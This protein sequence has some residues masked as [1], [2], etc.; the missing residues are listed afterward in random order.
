MKKLLTRLYID[1]FKSL[2]NFSLPATNEDALNQFVCLVGL[3]GSGK[4]SV[5][6]ALDFLSSL[7][8][9]SPF[10]W[11]QSRKWEPSSLMSRSSRKRTINFRLGFEVPG[12][13]TLAWQAS[14]NTIEARCITEELTLTLSSDRTIL[15]SESVSVKFER[16]LVRTSEGSPISLTSD[17]RGSV[18]STLKSSTLPNRARIAVMLLKHFLQGIKSLELL[19]PHLMRST[20]R[21]AVDVGVGGERLAAFINGLS[22]SEKKELS[23]TLSKFYPRLRAIGTRSAQYGWRRVFVREAYGD[24]IESDARHMND[25]MLRIAAIVAQT[26]AKSGFRKSIQSRESNSAT[27]DQDLG[28]LS[29]KEYALIL[30]DEI[31]NGVNPELVQLLIEYLTGVRQQVIVTTHSAL[32]LNYLTDSQAKDSVF[33]L[34]RRNDGSTG[35]KRLFDIPEARE[36]LEIMGP[37][38]AYLDVGLVRLSQI[39]A[40]RSV[41]P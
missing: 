31:E 3:N 18:F 34:F 19:S 22:N 23:T 21:E 16:G 36:R 7:V 28:N 30:L 4:S 11:L 10:R 32:I 39:E 8:V 14:Y 29:H 5:L 40:Q 25:G 13:G 2:V 38:E 6:Q 17:F 12:V 24:G 37:G 9:D 41:K 1:N 15:T 26:V 20:S 33:L 27:N 35:A